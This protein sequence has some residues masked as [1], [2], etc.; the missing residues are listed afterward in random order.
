ML[1]LK[2]KDFL[3]GEEAGIKN[4]TAIIVGARGEEDPVHAEKFCREN[5]IKYI[6]QIEPLK[7]WRETWNEL[8][9]QAI[10][11]GESLEPNPLRNMPMNMIIS[12]LAKKHGI[13]I[14]LLGEGADELFAGY[15]EFKEEKGSHVIEQKIV[16][17]VKGLH[18][19]QLQRV[20]RAS[21]FYTI[22]CRVP[23]LD[24]NIIEFAMQIDPKLLLKKDKNGNIQEK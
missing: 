9:E 10:Y 22:E 3:T 2:T 18:R 11:T 23:Y 16:N 1:K 13:K 20:D 5:N 15:P 4:V 7:T 17:F 8:I 21:M 14:C 6:K 19:T 12:K 24:K